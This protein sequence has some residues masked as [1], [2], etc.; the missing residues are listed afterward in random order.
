MKTHLNTYQKGFTLLEILLVI[1]LIVIL[2]GIVIVAINPINQ[3]GTARDAQRKSDIGT[4]YKA[5]NQYL[6]DHGSFPSTITSTLTPIC[7]SG[8]N[9]SPSCSGTVNLSSLVPTYIVSIPKDPNAT[10]DTGYRIQLSD[11]NVYIEASYTEIGFTNQPGYNTTPVVAFIGLVPQGYTPG[12]PGS[13]VGSSKIYN[14]G[15]TGPA[16]GFIFYVN[17]NYV[18][19]GW[20][21]LEAAPVD[22]STSRSWIQ[23]SFQ[24]TSIGGT[25]TAIGTGLSN[26]NT[27]N[28]LTTNSAAGVAKAYSLN[29]FSDWFLPSR[30]EL[31][32]M[33]TNLYKHVP[34]LGGFTAIG[35][36]SSSEDD[37]THAWRESFGGTTW[38][39]M[40]KGN[41]YYVRAIRRF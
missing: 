34:S 13:L 25:S 23:T 24:S 28:S 35:Y 2:T 36:W 10:I 30:Q 7:N 5:V 4:I 27:I 41:T 40:F 37:E 11:N 38:T 1:A 26:T 31:Y 18:T 21:Y 22:Q 15:D 6:I 29:G 19:D 12:T 3:L 17:P 33:Y 39:S 9:I 8:S 14:I 32:L 16:G 20:T